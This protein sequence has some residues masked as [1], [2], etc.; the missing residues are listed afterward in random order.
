[1]VLSHRGGKCQR[2]VRVVPKGANTGKRPKAVTVHQEIFYNIAVGHNGGRAGRRDEIQSDKKNVA[3][4]F[5]R[6][7][8]E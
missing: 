1:M 7:R 5:R 4:G 3:K 8:T 2:L 6:R